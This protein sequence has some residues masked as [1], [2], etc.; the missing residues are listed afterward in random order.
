MKAPSKPQKSL[1]RRDATGHLNPKYAADL[2]RQSLA[3]GRAA[4]GSGNVAFLERA[5]SRDSLAEALGEEFLEAATTGEGAGVDA[6]N[7]FVP[8]DDGGPFVITRAR[9]EFAREPDASNPLEATR[10]PFPTTVSPAEDG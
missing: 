7:R 2:R 4:D 10:E 8:E 1:Q 9:D 5:R 3:S 6:R